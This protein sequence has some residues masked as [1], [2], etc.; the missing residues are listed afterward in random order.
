M[1]DY[2]KFLIFSFKHILTFLPLF[3]RYFIDITFYIVFCEYPLATYYE[4][5]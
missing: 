4:Y 3:T 2:F 5:S 1:N